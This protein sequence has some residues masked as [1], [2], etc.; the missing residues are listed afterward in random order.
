MYK[1]WGFIWLLWCFLC[2][3][4]FW[5]VISELSLLI[6]YQALIVII[7]SVPIVLFA[8]RVYAIIR[9]WEY[10]PTPTFGMKFWRI[11]GKIIV[12]LLQASVVAIFLA[13][14]PLMIVGS[15]WWKR[16]ER[17]TERLKYEKE[18]GYPVVWF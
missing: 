14:L 17:K 10:E 8:L 9:Y 11:V 5:L 2:L 1:F 18:W 15:W 6:I 3:M 7:G 12:F 4:Y 16:K 13:L